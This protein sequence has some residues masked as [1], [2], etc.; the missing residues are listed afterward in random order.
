MREDKNQTDT[1]KDRRQA[2]A[3]E[4]KQQGNFGKGRAFGGMGVLHP[5][6]DDCSLSH[7]FPDFRI[8]YG[9]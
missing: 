3:K 1:R 5:V 6:G 9:K 2:D 8:P 7:Y 4:D